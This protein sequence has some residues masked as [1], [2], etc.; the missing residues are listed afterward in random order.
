MVFRGSWPI[1][2][3]FGYRGVMGHGPWSNNLYNFDMYFPSRSNESLQS[4]VLLLT[5]RFCLY[6]WG[7]GRS[8]YSRQHGPTSAQGEHRSGR[9]WTVADAETAQRKASFT[10]ARWL[11]EGTKAYLPSLVLR[12]KTALPL[13]NCDPCSFQWHVG[14]QTLPVNQKDTQLLDLHNSNRVVHFG[15]SP[16]RAPCVEREIRLGRQVWTPC[17]DWATKLA[18]SKPHI[19]TYTSALQEVLWWLLGI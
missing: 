5:H 7:R 16:V 14:K 18:W 13:R 4:G 10:K 17:D 2:D 3:S 19:E 12:W 9:W 1:L 11:L 8:C 6:M 15:C